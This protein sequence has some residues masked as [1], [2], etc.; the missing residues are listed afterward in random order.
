[1]AKYKSG[2]GVERVHPRGAV[3]FARTSY[4][5][6]SIAIQ[7]SDGLPDGSQSREGAFVEIVHDFPVVIERSPIALISRTLNLDFLGGEARSL[8]R[9]DEV[10]VAKRKPLSNLFRFACFHFSVLRF[11]ETIHNRRSH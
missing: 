8:N 10:V 1:M 7:R 9:I 5:S 11:L 6:L 4:D 3:D 2:S